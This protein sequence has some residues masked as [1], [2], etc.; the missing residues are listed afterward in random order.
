VISSDAGAQNQHSDR[1]LKGKTSSGRGDAG[2]GYHRYLGIGAQGL[3]QA[4]P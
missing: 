4:N 2:I 3:A 1:S